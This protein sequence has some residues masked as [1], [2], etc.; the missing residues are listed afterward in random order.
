MIQILWIIFFIVVCLAGLIISVFGGPGPFIIF[1]GILFYAIIDHFHDI[2]LGI[3]GILLILSIAG[4]ILEFL[5][6]LIGA[7]K[8]GASRAGIIG[9]LIGGI[10]GSLIGT[11]ILPVI[12]SILGALFGV[13]LGAFTV[14]L[15][16]QKNIYNSFKSG[17]GAFVGRLGGS[18]TK[19]VLVIIMAIIVFNKIF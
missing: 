11:L 10:M 9:A 13:F 4:E 8:F 1:G 2:D 14:E 6:G 5:S 16:I 3:L 19:L 12:G 18:V 15:I 17:L 7:K